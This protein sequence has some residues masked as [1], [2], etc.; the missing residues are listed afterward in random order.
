MLFVANKT[1]RVC[2]ADVLTRASGQSMRDLGLDSTSKV[3]AFLLKRSAKQL[4][5]LALDVGINFTASLACF[6][7]LHALVLSAQAER[8]SN[9][10]ALPL[11]GLTAF[12]GGWFLTT[13][14]ARAHVVGGLVRCIYFSC[15]FADG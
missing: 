9:L 1:K 8:M 12:G 6:A 13:V 4:A 15:V 2:C 3:R 5:Y 10:V 7:T 11:C 14:R